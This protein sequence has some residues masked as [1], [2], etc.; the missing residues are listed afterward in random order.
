MTNHWLKE[1]ESQQQNPD[2]SEN[3][4]NHKRYYFQVDSNS[5]YLTQRQMDIS[6]LLLKNLTYRRIGEQLGIGARTV[7]CH[8]NLLR[9]K[10]NCSNKKVLINKLK[11]LLRPENN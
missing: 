10:L 1:I 11:Q 3:K 7:E 8:V 6:L 4:K 5:M 2:V 9:M